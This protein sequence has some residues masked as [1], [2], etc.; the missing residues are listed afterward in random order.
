M[1]NT[2]KQTEAA[3]RE[4]AK[5]EPRYLGM[6]IEKQRVAND[7]TWVPYIDQSQLR[8]VRSYIFNF[9]RARRI[10]GGGEMLPPAR[11]S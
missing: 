11:R 3:S 7:R 9:R 10:S 6:E 5:E 1:K 8:L 2:T 4:A